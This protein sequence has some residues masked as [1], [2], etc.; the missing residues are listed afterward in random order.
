[1]GFAAAKGRLELDDRLAALVVEPLGHLD[2]QQPHALGDIGPLKKSR[3][4]LI[5]SRGLAGLHRRNIG[6]KFGLLKRTFQYV[7]MGN[8][9]FSPGFH[10]FC[11]CCYGKSE[12]F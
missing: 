3:R 6:G 5:L 11:S 9:Y 1:M 4:V 2:Q 10:T 8:G 7:G 12:D